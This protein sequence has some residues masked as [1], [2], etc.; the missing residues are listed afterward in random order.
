MVVKRLL[1][2]PIIQLPHP[3]VDVTSIAALPAASSPAFHGARI[4]TDLSPSGVL[5][6]ELKGSA[7]SHDNCSMEPVTS[8]SFLTVSS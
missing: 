4:E 2:G 7:I 5:S 3:R 1:A 6:R 8:S